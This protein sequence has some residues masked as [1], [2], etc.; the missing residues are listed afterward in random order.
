MHGG[1][2]QGGDPQ[3]DRHDPAAEGQPQA[4]STTTRSATSS[5][6]AARTSAGSQGMPG[7]DSY[8]AL[9]KLDAEAQSVTAIDFD[10]DGKPDICLV[11][12]EQGR[13]APERR[14]RVHRGRRCPASPA[15]RAPRCGP[16]TTAT[17]CPTCSSPRPTGP[18]LF[19]NLG[20]GQFRDDT[21][22]AAEGSRVQ[23]HRRRVGRLRRRR[24]A[25]HRPRQR[26]P[27]P[28][29]LPQHPARTRRR[30]CCPK[31]GDWHAIGTFRATNAGRQLQDRVRRSRRSRSTP[32]K[33][34]KGK[35]DMPAKWAKK[36][37][38]DGEATPLPEVG[39]NCATYLHREIE[40]ATAAEVPVVARQRRHADGVAQRREG[41][42]Q[43]QGQARRRPPL[44]AEAEGREE[45]AAGEDVR[46]G[47]GA[48]VLV[49]A[50]PA[51]TPARSGRGSRTFPTAWGFGPNGL[52]ADVKG[53]TL[54][55]AD[56]TG[57]GKPD[58]L[59]GAGTGTAA[60]EPGRQ[61]RH[62]GRQRHQLQARQ[63]RP[64]ARATSTAT[65]SS[66]CSSRRPTGS[67]SCSAT[68]APASS[69]T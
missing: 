7:F 26:L 44:V 67:A 5:A 63:G 60:R 47:R 13:A 54:A 69:P 58:I 53:D 57:D 17:A 32:D 55:V 50:R 16:T 6:G 20:K 68:T 46:R 9:A 23:P 59:Y 11:R 4:Q 1:R 62:Q 14:R 34:Y 18:R 22:P 12:G 33:E 8:A 36:D 2:R 24:Q 51:A 39:G 66:T 56:F 3:E 25:R 15:A 42:Q 52:C 38:K 41:T 29:R 40:V 64:G 10:N 27:R 28:A 45:H 48:R 49:R 61:V 43:R 37:I 35:R 31:F 21:A 65:A 30:S 19:T